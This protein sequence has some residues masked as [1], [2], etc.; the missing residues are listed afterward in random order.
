VQRLAFALAVA[1]AVLGLRFGTFVAS[2]ADSYGY[3]SQADLWLKRT[4][5]LQQPFNG[6]APWRW[7]NWTLS[8]LG[9]RPGDRGG[10]MVPTY[11]P[12]LPMLMAVFKAVGGERAIYFVVPLLGALAV[13][14][15][16]RLGLA[17]GD[18]HA[19]LLAAF[20]LLVSPAFL[21]QLMWP[22]S[23]VP[24]LAWWLLAA[25]LAT[26]GSRAHAGLSGF[27]A[28]AAILTRPNLAPLVIPIAAALVV[29]APERATHASPL[30][31]VTREGAWPHVT[32]EGAWRAAVFVLAMLPG[33]IAVAV[34]NNY[35]YGSPLS[36]GYGSFSTIYAWRYVWANV[37]NYPLWLVQT[38]TPFILLALAA[39]VLLRRA[40]RAATRR[41]AFLGL[42]FAL[43][44]LLLYLW[45]TPFDTWVYLRFLLP[46]YPM[47][48]VVAAAAFGLLAPVEPRRRLAA[49]ATVALALAVW[50]GW[51]GR[52]AFSV[53]KE[54]ARYLAA[55]RFA[56]AL[57]ENA[58]ILANQHS[59]SLRYYA[60]RDTLRIEWLAPDVY[61]EALR[62]VRGQG[63]PVFAVLDDAER[64]MFRSRYRDVADLS[65]LDRE[66]AIVAAG[67][68]YF[69]EVPPI[70]E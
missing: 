23:D 64:E 16:F 42:A 27:A 43:V 70:I 55:A 24:V 52:A 34:I 4:L 41:L 10:T 11:S 19:A 57:P 65:W 26:G 31:H 14:L 29:L 50:G 30:P 61:A 62:Y 7:A 40:G 8:P 35:L 12:G 2:G 28:A 46:A 21:F 15:T 56:T 33:P 6:E 54:E 63:H 17:F 25:V 22:M 5:V 32:R 49:F 69:Y 47:M 67:G 9:Y 36:S 53:R 51:Q 60:H 37:V 3:V 39:P 59:G 20:A 48:L 1:A 13:W 45:Y 44:V 66:P 58:V 68:V 18:P 38:Q